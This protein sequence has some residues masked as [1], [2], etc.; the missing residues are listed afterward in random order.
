MTRLMMTI[1][2]TTSCVHFMM[3]L[4]QMKRSLQVI[5][6]IYLKYHVLHYK[7]GNIYGL[8]MISFLKAELFLSLCLLSLIKVPRRLHHKFQWQRKLWLCLLRLTQRRSIL[9]LKYHST[10]PRKLFNPTSS[11]LPQ[12]DCIQIANIETKLVEVLQLIEKIWCK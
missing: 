12:V 4:I 1:N 3:E 10:S 2:L 11:V 7:E 9:H 6:R 8:S 5:L